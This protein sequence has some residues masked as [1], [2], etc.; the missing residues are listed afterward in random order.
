MLALLLQ[1]PVLFDILLLLS[2]PMCLLLAQRLFWPLRVSCLLGCPCLEAS[3][4]LF[5]RIPA[6][7]D[8]EAIGDC[9]SVLLVLADN[10]H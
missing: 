7:T 9:F 6:K 8:D 5:L 2:V 3:D 4:L 1:L 10:C